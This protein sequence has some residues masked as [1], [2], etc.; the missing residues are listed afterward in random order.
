MDLERSRPRWST[1]PGGEPVSAPGGASPGTF[2]GAAPCLRH[3]SPPHE[4]AGPLLAPRL[5]T[6][7]TQ[8]PGHRQPP[9]LTPVGHRLPAGAEASP[10]PQRGP[11]ASSELPSR[12]D[13]GLAGSHGHSPAFLAERAE[14]S[15]RRN[16][17][18]PTRLQRRS[19]GG[20]AWPP[21]GRPPGRAGPSPPRAPPS[22]SPPRLCSSPAPSLLLAFSS[23]FWGRLM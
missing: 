19:R 17:P 3:A 20:G 7:S 16:L 15:G 12:R 10:G 5:P 22:P 13:R 9:P 2:R 8:E 23:F 18:G 14:F 4:L 6:A 1:G 21:R 11:A